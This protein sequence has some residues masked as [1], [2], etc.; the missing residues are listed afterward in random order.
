MPG[1]QEYVEPAAADV[2][3]STGDEVHGMAILLDREAEARMDLHEVVGFGYRKKY[4]VFEAYDGRKLE[5]GRQC[6]LGYVWLLVF[7]RYGIFCKSADTIFGR[8]SFYLHIGK[9]PEYRL[10]LT[11]IANR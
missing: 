6:F 11:D 4:V 1:G 7:D 3:E 9:N 10:R 8:M 2:I 5:G